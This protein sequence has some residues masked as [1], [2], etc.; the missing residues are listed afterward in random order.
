MVNLT[1]KERTAN[2]FRGFI[3]P[4][5]MIC[6]IVAGVAIACLALVVML[7]GIQEKLAFYQGDKAYATV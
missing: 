2:D 1:F 3:L 5:K 6:V 4:G 7:I